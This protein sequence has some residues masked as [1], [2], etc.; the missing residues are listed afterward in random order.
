MDT[1]NNPTTQNIP[2]FQFKK[3]IR[4]ETVFSPRSIAVIGATDEEGSVGRSI[5]LNLVQNRFGGVVYPVHSSLDAILG[6]K[7]YKNIAD[8]PDDIDLAVILTR[9]KLVPDVLRDCVENNVKG[10]VIISSGFRETGSY[11]HNL[12]NEIHEIA[13]NSDMRIIGPN[14]LGIMMPNSG[15][16]ATC[17]KHIAMPG[18]IGFISQSGALCTAIL[19]WSLQENIGFSAF[20]SVGSMVDVNWGD[21]IDYLGNDAKTKTIAIYMESIGNARAFLSAAREVALRKPIIVIK[22]GR[23]EGASRAMLSHTGSTAGHD[24]ALDAAFRRIGVLR[25]DTIAELFY[26]AE[27]L[28]KQPRPRG[29]RLAILTNAGGPGVLAAD[30]LIRHG[31]KLAEL[32]PE[33]MTALD[34]ILSK[35]WSHCNPI[36]LQGDATPEVYSKALEIISKDPE[37]DGILVILSPQAMT[38]PT[39]TAEK[40]KAFKK[41]RNKPILT[42]WMGG[43]DVEKGNAILSKA[44]IP[45]YPYPDT[46]TR[47]FNYMWRYSYN[48]KGLYETPAQAHAENGDNKLRKKIA[49]EIDA[50]RK[51]GRTKLTAV[52]SKLMLE[53]YGIPVAQST[54]VESEAEA[55]AAAEKTGYPVVLKHNSEK[56]T[57]KRDR[58][59]VK[60]NLVNK[61]EVAGAFKAIQSHISQKLGTENFNG[62]LVQPMVNYDGYELI[63]GVSTDTQIGPVLQ[64]GSGG[65]LVE[66]FRD[67]S[68]ALPPLNTTLARRMME[69]TNIYGAMKNSTFGETVNLQKLEKLLVKFSYLVVEQRW[70]KEIDI[71]PLLVRSSVNDDDKYGEFVALDARIVLHAPKLKEQDLPKLAIRPYPVEYV[72][73][74]KLRTGET[75]KIRPIRPEDEPEI[76]DFHQHLSEESIYFRYF[77][78]VA[79]GQRIDHDRLA[80]ICFNDFDREMALVVEST[81]SDEKPKIIGVGRL[82]RIPGKDDAE[83]AVLI[84]DSYQRTGLG[85]QLLGALLSIGK[86]EN[87]KRVFAQILLENR[88]MQRV[89]EKLGFEIKTDYEEQVVHASILV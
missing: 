13:Q 88:G 10:A 4:L 27:I 37:S 38:D 79:L 39:K 45:T 28:S 89:C 6:I 73:D 14:C 3:K 62:I 15:L 86:A 77:H 82:T 85:T 49:R 43:A 75:V 31:G 1:P 81:K 87:I 42:S 52:E 36:D 68:L 21:L 7:A 47:I 70:I 32:A 63:I 50:I 67:R 56:I 12:E 8:I 11:G 80:Q 30:S 46:A 24:E 61:D 25:V 29:S 34:D 23:T 18:N 84:S 74:C 78:P 55:I 40:L 58:S 33:T 2:N 71:N 59:S 54:V 53:S 66:V 19:D 72:F 51:A 22:A 26:M 48:L 16:N 17:A 9:A 83:F 57:N 20:V 41:I 65:Q 44:D 76:V 64:F 69:Q 35:N 5:M 60:L